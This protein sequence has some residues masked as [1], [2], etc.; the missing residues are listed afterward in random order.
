MIAD[1]IQDTG[2]LARLDTADLMESLAADADGSLTADVNTYLEAWTH[3]IRAWQSAGVAPSEYQ[4]LDSL[5]SGIEAAQ[6]V[7]QFF[8]MLKKLPPTQPAGT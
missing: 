1:P 8:V 5:V 7:V 4:E 2:L 6:R 3:Q